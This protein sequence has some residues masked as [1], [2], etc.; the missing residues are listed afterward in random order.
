MPL[1]LGIFAKTFARP[2]LAQTL[3]AVA[4]SG[5]RCVQFN[6]ACCGVPTVPQSLDASLLKS[7]QTELQS[8]SIAVAA[9]SATFNL[10]HPDSTQ[11]R[12][13]LQ[14]LPVLARA[15]QALDC[16]LLT[17]CTGTRDPVD[18]WRAHSDNNSPEAWADLRDS[19][20][21]ALHITADTGIALGIEPELSNVVSSA[22]ACHRLLREVGS[23]RLRV[24]YDGA[25]LLQPQDLGRQSEIFAEALDLLGPSIALTHAKELD[26]HGHPGNLGPG[27]GSLDW[28]AWFAGLRRIGYQ[29]PVILH[30]LAEFEVPPAIRFLSPFL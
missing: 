19:I 7:V 11:R 23:P 12:E 14:R 18:M 3:D 5:L 1:T 8:R 25:N 22:K 20:D 9:L 10:I 26:A 30:G 4:N 15:A 24:V 29:G 2:A 6:F 21:H 13:G 27:S 16:P 17:L 28:P